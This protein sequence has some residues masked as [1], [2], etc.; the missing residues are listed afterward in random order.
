MFRIVRSNAVNVGQL[1]R[2]TTFYHGAISGA[3]HTRYLHQTPVSQDIPNLEDNPTLRK[4]RSN[5]R[6]MKAMIEAM[7]LLQSKNFI[8][9]NSTKPPSIMKMM[10]MMQDPEVK[11][12]F[13]EMQELLTKEGISFSPSDLSA[14][15]GFGNTMAGSNRDDINVKEHK[16]LGDGTKKSLFN[17]FADKFKSK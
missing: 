7:Q 16:E 17:R 5:P 12:K 13:M 2:R 11:Q 4:L 1:F 6:V 8:D 3:Q 15:M 14:F 10:Q 9:P